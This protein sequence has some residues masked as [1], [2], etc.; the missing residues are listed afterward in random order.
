MSNA[1]CHLTGLKTF[2]IITKSLHTQIGL[3][4]ANVDRYTCLKNLSFNRFK[5]CTAY[6][7]SPFFEI[8]YAMIMSLNSISE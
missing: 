8:V 6:D 5:L 2:S 1:I 4:Y 3:K 7:Y